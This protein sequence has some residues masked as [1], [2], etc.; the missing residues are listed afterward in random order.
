MRHLTWI[1]VAAGLTLVLPVASAQA[2][3]TSKDGSF[4]LAQSGTVPGYTPA[5][6]NPSNCGTP[7]TPASCGG[8]GGGGGTTTH[9]AHK[10]HTAPVRHRKN[11]TTG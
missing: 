3:G 5:P 4:M 8:G 11:T 9:K 1:V 6:L 10:A 2:A 7:D